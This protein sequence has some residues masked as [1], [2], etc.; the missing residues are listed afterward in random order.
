MS[1]II[2][3]ALYA[4]GGGLSTGKS[5]L[6]NSTVNPSYFGAD[7]IFNVEFTSN[8]TSYSMFRLGRAANIIL[9]DNTLVCSSGIMQEAYRQITF[10]EP[11]IGD[12]LTWLQANAIQQS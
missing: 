3:K 6:L 7:K 1:K 11:A 4:G 8:N 12:L 2:G 10:A 5:W 9:Y